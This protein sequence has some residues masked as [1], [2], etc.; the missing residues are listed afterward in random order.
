LSLGPSR[1][2]ARH[3]AVRDFIARRTRAGLK[4][5]EETVGWR[6][7]LHHREAELSKNAWRAAASFASQPCGDDR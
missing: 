7:A 4:Q 1:P 5:S 6:F 3:A 2:I